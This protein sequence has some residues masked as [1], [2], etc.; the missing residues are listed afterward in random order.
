MADL[1]GSTRVSAA[2][3]SVTALTNV[4]FSVGTTS[5]GVITKLWNYE[6]L[7]IYHDSVEWFD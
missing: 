6:I 1:V 2:E 3:Y 5:T 7:K 4:T